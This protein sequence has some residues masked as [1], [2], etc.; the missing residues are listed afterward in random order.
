M[1]AR[2]PRARSFVVLV[3][4][5]EEYFPELLESVRQGVDASVTGLSIAKLRQPKNGGL[6]VEINGGSKS[7]EVVREEILRTFGPSATV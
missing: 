7:A 1:T 2:P 5:G 4:R 6:L 3:K